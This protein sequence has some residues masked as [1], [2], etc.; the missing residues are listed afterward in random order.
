MCSASE[1]S[2]GHRRVAEAASE[3]RA[4]P[5]GGTGRRGKQRT[6]GAEKRT[7]TVVGQR[8]EPDGTDGAQ[9]ASEK[10]PQR[11]G[12]HGVFLSDFISSRVYQF[13]IC[14]SDVSSS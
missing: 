10:R 8:E 5:N 3:K 13:E 7:T 9:A 2:F 12:V 14:L 6:A 4:R 1:K 11:R